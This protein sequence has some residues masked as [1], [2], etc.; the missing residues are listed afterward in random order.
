MRK[1]VNLFNKIFL[2]ILLFVGIY[3]II[4]AQEQKSWQW[5]KQLGSVSWD[6]TNGVVCD[7]DNNLYIT[8]CFSEKISCDNKAI[9]SL[10]GQDVFIARFDE[11]GTIEKLWSGGGKGRDQAQCITISMDNNIVIGGL[12]TDVVTFNDIT[13]KEKGRRLF[14]SSLDTKG[15]FRWISTL[16]TTSEAS[17][18]LLQASNN[19]AIYAAGTFTGRLSG[20]KTTIE[21]TGKKDIFLVK[22]NNSGIVEKLINLGGDED[23]MPTALSVSE[24]GNIMLAGN[25]GKTFNVDS[26]VLNAHEN[27]TKSNTFLIQFD[28]N[29]N[30]RWNTMI[31]GDE[32]CQ[33]N[34][35]AQNRDGDIFLTGS[36]NY[37]IQAADTLFFSTGYTD[38]FLMKYN[39]AGNLLWGRNFGTW[40]YDYTTH[41]NI[42][43]LGGALITGSIG[44][45]LVI[46]NLMVNPLEG[47]N[48]AL[49]IQ[50][51]SDGLAIWGDCISG[52]GRNFGYG[53][54]LD[55]KGN[56][57]L[58]GA[59]RNTFEKESVKFTSRGDQDV[60]LAKYYNCKDKN[61]VIQGNT[62]ICPGASTELYINNG[63]NFVTWND[64]IHDQNY[65]IADKPG[66]YRVTMMDKRGC[67]FTDSLE[68]ELADK[69]LFTLGEDISKLVDSVVILYAPGHFTN[70]CW[71]DNSNN[72]IFT[73]K[74]ENRQDGKYTY[75]LSV[76]DS[77]GCTA[78]DT[79][80]V[81]FYNTPQSIDWES[82]EILSYPNPVSDYLYWKL[83]G[84]GPYQLFLEIT[85]ENGKVIFNQHISQYFPGEIQKIDFRNFTYGIYYFRLKDSSGGQSRSISVIRL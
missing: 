42:D 1:T 14:I 47:N 44:D 39:N 45:T 19:G 79:I 50:F 12:I 21:S 40:Y 23:D 5:V 41:L 69:P 53:S 9:K 62:T 32:Y 43:K 20:G 27:I 17:L 22:L 36:F 57:Y 85:D 7:E 46:D 61:A 75:W 48:S 37:S 2:I 51:S 33:V 63:Y 71:Q 73:A 38:G 52:N 84:D 15:K 10:G 64:S 58:T 25:T 80:S 66:I 78:S 67:I 8:G 4:H 30:A 28:E 70:Y 31:Y 76:T 34:S 26:L 16:Q 74:A 56:L 60:F 72:Q 24:S 68:I 35:L 83:G 49:A 13:N 55:Q 81:F 18:F 3:N 82:V 29:F 65:I 54:A 77:L 6:Q 59:F 11:K